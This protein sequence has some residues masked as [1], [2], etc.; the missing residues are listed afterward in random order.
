ML[1]IHLFEK[2]GEGWV[3]ETYQHT[4]CREDVT[5]ALVREHHGGDEHARAIRLARVVPRWRPDADVAR[6]QPHL[7]AQVVGVRVTAGDRV[8]HS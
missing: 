1:P 3:N 8:L 6:Q 4:C 7:G 2:K 5:T